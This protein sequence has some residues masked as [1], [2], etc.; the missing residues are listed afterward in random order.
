MK[1]TLL[2]TISLFILS[3]TAL[4]SQTTGYIKFPDPGTNAY[5]YRAAATTTNN[6]IT[7]G[8][9]GLGGSNHEIIY[10][11]VNFQPLWS[12]N[13][14]SSVVQNWVDVIETNDGNFIALGFNPNRNGCN[15]AIKVNPSGTVLW[16]KEYY[17]SGNFLTS[18]ALS[19]AAGN[20]PGFVFGGGAC[21]ASSFLVRC[22]ANGNIVWQHEYF[23]TGMTGVQTTD[24]IIAENNAYI[25][26]GNAQNGSAN[27]AWMTKVDS[28]GNWIFTSLV[29]EPTYNQIPYRMVKLSTGNYAM[30]C[31]YNSNPNYAQIVYYFGPTGNVIQASKFL[32][33]SQSE[34]QFYDLTETSAG[35]VLLVGTV[36]DNSTLK[37]LYMELSATG[38]VNWQKKSI[39]VTPGYLNGT[40]YAVQPTPGGNFA[41][42]GY[43]YTDQRTI[44]VID[45]SGNGYCNGTTITM[46]A[47]TADAYTVSSNTPV[48]IPPNILVA[49]VT[50]VGTP[51]VLT[52]TNMC[53]AVG[54]D[55]LEPDA[56]TVSVFPN[57]ANDKITL[58][59]GDKDLSNAVVSFWNVLGE[60][61]YSVTNSSATIDISMLTAG[62]YLIEVMKDGERSVSRLVKE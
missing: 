56:N 39:G 62:V 21:A 52:R 13:Y 9:G 58:V 8:T 33:P 14:P 27:D 55:E 43:A 24:A 51:L 54:E 38:S 40:A 20:D 34:I 37:Y 16:Q 59:M 25:L 50:N 47:G 28:A 30:V 22:D 4:L 36:Y 17:I 2:T 5:I 48:I 1:K 19:K 41:I 35:K 61:V 3:G 31:G 49:T 32:G 29:A 6:F 7:I 45:G 23:L 44:A 60:K 10:W 26:G 42:F 46:P 53:G 57:P 11:D 18:F 15:I 12:L